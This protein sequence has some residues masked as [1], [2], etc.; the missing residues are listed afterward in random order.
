MKTQEDLGLPCF[1]PLQHLSVAADV[2]SL[3]PAGAVS[4]R[5]PT[6]SV[7]FPLPSSAPAWKTVTLQPYTGFCGSAAAVRAL[8]ACH[9]AEQLTI[10]VPPTTHRLGLVLQ[11]D[12]EHEAGAALGS[13]VPGFRVENWS[14]NV[15]CRSS[16]D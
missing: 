14:P 4:Q 1:P 5:L 16:A 10:R 13:R 7:E 11:G 8:L 12:A 3:W 6:A 15:M 9:P 2:I